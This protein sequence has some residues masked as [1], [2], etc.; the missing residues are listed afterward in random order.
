MI[1]PVSSV[2]FVDYSKRTYEIREE[3]RAAHKN[4]K[5]ITDCPYS[6]LMAIW[7]SQGWKEVKL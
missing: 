6:G 1:S 3:G 7:W 2:S 4:G 5:P